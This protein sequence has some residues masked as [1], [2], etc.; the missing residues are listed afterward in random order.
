MFT[1]CYFLHFVYIV[2]HILHM[3][4]H[5]TTINLSNIITIIIIKSNFEVDI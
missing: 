2:V 3:N 5:V 4:P 1:L